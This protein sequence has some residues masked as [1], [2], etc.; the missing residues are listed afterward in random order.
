MYAAWGG[1]LKTRG[2]ILGMKCVVVDGRIRDLAELRSDGLPVCNKKKY[3]Y[4]YIFSYFYYIYI[5]FYFI[6]FFFLK[7]KVFARETSILSA[8]AFSRPTA[9]NIPITL[10][11]NHDPPIKINPGDIILGDLDGVVCIPKDLLDQV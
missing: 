6:L 11:G 4:I 8:S 1:L 9:L 5:Y 7:K 3:I 2:T 10:N